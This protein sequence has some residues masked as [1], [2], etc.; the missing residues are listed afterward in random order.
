MNLRQKATGHIEAI[1]E[2]QEAATPTTRLIT[3]AAALTAELGIA[4]AA[5]TGQQTWKSRVLAVWALAAACAGANR[6]FQAWLE[7]QATQ[8][9]LDG[10]DTSQ[11]AAQLSHSPAFQEAVFGKDSDAGM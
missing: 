10:M 8:A 9:E 7:Q 4:A 3:S 6:T 1:R 11:L 5:F 2:R